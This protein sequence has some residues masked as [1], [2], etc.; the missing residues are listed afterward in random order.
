M[1]K[2]RSGGADFEPP[3]AGI[4]CARLIGY[5]ELGKHE[6]EYQGQK[7]LRDKVD[8]IFELSGP[9]HPPRALADGTKVPQRIAVKETLDLS[10]DSNF[11][12]LFTMMN[13]A[14]KATHMAQLLGDAFLV[15]IFHRKSRD[16]KKTFANLKGP[17]GYN[18]RNSIY[19]DLIIGKTITIEI[20]PPI[21]KLRLFVWTT[22]D[23]KDWYNLYMPGEYE[24]VHDSE[25]NLVTPTRSKNV[26]QEQ[27]IQA[28]NWP[29]HPLASVVT[30]GEEEKPVAPEMHTKRAPIPDRRRS[31]PHAAFDASIDARKRTRRQQDIPPTRKQETKGT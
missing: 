8:L 21:T 17:N 4:A 28:V 23:V 12:K 11:L 15:E 5:F 7:R 18:I 14:A 16:G 25:G 2:P 6:Q 3:A 22:A 20:A 30:L 10:K 19:Q 9:N 29:E 26:L 31:A 27:I 1:R 13:Y 24:E